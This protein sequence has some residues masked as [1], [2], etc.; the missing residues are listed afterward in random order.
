M[1]AT[2]LAREFMVKTR[3]RKG[4]TDDLTIMKFFDDP[5]LLELARSDQDL[6]DYFQ[7]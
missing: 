6:A 4:L 1:P 5:N 3:K 2:H 7:S